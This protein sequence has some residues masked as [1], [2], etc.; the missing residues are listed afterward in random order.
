MQN[1]PV[2]QV[3][4]IPIIIEV[5]VERIIEK[6]VQIERVVH[7]PVER[8][9]E[10]PV[11]RVIPVKKE[12]YVE[13]KKVGLGL[14]L[15]QNLSSVV[16]HV[17][18]LLKYRI[19][20]LPDSKV[21]RIVS[22][23]VKDVVNGFGADACGNI[24][25]GDVL[26]SIDGRPLSGMSL[27]Q[28]KSLMLGS[29]GTFCVLDLMRDGGPPFKVE[30]TR[31]GNTPFRY[32][33][34][35]YPES[36]APDDPTAQGPVRLLDT[37][38]AQYASKVQAVEAERTRRQPELGREVQAQEER[39]TAFTPTHAII[40]RSIGK[41][42]VSSNLYF[43]LKNPDQYFGQVSAGKKLPNPSRHA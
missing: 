38:P 42:S 5:P 23:T 21:D 36:S 34:D 2:N 9:V 17:E 3:V 32:W 6:R 41:V 39:Y 33:Q 40:E 18:F 12:V 25:L 11:E 7:I 43:F 10:Y 37:A 16:S 13:P 8:I 14:V 19:R 22:V 15:E 29:P 30:V 28:V 26:L 35:T 20:P 24:V 4:E 31:I 27:D 1:I